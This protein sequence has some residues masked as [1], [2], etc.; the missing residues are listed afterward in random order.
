MFNNS[1]F[2]AYKITGILAKIDI[3]HIPSVCY[4]P[5]EIEMED[6]LNKNG[7][8]S[9]TVSS[10]FRKNTNIMINNCFRTIFYLTKKDIN[11]VD[12]K[13]TFND[14]NENCEIQVGAFFNVNSIS[15][16]CKKSFLDQMENFYPRK[17]PIEK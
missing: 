3:P 12:W 15:E 2:H 7:L 13:D 6:I 11:I 14:L 1:L 8:W 17:S 4:K 5:W 16:K 9:Q 10:K